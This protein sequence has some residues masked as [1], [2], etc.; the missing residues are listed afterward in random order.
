L[1]LIF[2]FCLF[3]FK[4]FFRFRCGEF[5][6]LICLSLFV[7]FTGSQSSIMRA[8]FMSVLAFVHKRHSLQIDTL[9]T[10]STALI[11][12]TLMDPSSLLSPGFILS[13]AATASLCIFGNLWSQFVARIGPA[14]NLWETFIYQWMRL[15]MT[16]AFIFFTTLPLILY[17]FH[18]IHLGSIF[19]NLIYPWLLGFF[20]TIGSLCGILG[21]LNMSLGKECLNLLYRIYDPLL[22]G[23][24]K[25]Q[26]QE[27]G[28]I[29]LS[30]SLFFPV[31]S[32]IFLLL[33]IFWGI[34]KK[35][36]VI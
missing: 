35:K 2:S 19:F 4:N 26:T 31:F 29:A 15:F 36:Q 7:L 17:F 34:S 18:K 16:Q 10:L 28:L 6:G 8:Y 3:G 23:L 14:S 25:P 32:L 11:L 33:C 27:W 24:D 22:S 9:H 20:M 21:F 12:S 13:Y 5:L 1:N 30:P